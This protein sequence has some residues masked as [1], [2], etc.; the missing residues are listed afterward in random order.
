MPNTSKALTKG[1]SSK[2]RISSMGSSDQVFLALFRVIAQMVGESGS[3]LW[4][5]RA[6]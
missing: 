4:A 3:N 6:L 1:K 2:K 5:K